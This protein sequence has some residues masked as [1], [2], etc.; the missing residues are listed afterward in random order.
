[1]KS[2]IK[3]LKIADTFT[4]KKNETIIDVRRE[5]T[6]HFSVLN[7]LIEFTTNKS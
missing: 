3:L 7:S 1:M 4:R 5:R 2:I 6:R